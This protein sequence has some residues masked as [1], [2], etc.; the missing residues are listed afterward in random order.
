MSYAVILA[1]ADDVHAQAV[2]LSLHEHG[3]DKS[4]IVDLSHI[5]NDACLTW[6]PEN[7]IHFTSDE[8]DI[9]LTCATS[10]WWRRPAYPT[11][12]TTKNNS[13][14]DYQRSEFSE[15]ISGALNELDHLKLIKND[16]RT[17][18]LANSKIH[19]L[20]LAEKHGLKTPRTLITNSQ[21][22]ALDFFSNEECQ[23]IAKGFGGTK[24]HFSPTQLLTKDELLQKGNVSLSPIIFQERVVATEEIRITYAFG[25]LFA[26]KIVSNLK[27]SQVDWRIDNAATCSEFI[28]P[29][30]VRKPL[31]EM[32]SSLGMS[33]C[34]VDM[35]IDS[36]GNYYF[37]EINECGQ[38]LFVEID[39]GMPITAAI[40][41]GLL[42]T[43]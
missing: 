35:I 34:T 5:G 4:A 31:S 24:E 12:S 6:T 38:Y 30:E 11:F 13:I 19:Q 33:Y 23:Y 17:R 32:L 16:A 22:S 28:L 29:R 25:K 7:G 43:L 20:R 3:S 27:P 2:L 39:T 41:A 8:I 37:L 18:G 40:A 14:R 10:I 1:P 21:K 36:G 15:F 9:N 42:G 26:A